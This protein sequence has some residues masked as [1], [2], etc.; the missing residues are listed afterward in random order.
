L[1]VCLGDLHVFFLRFLKVQE[2]EEAVQEEE[3]LQYHIVG[4]HLRQY[5]QSQQN[6]TDLELFS[7]FYCHMPTRDQVAHTKFIFDQ[8][9]TGIKRL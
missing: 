7:M 9:L 5:M 8:W 1:A 4:Y 6:W 2:E 3:S